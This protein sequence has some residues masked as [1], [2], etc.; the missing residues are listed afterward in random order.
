MIEERA[1]VGFD[2]GRGAVGEFSL[3]VFGV[4]LPEEDEAG[5]VGGPDAGGDGDFGFG[6]GVWGLGAIGDLFQGEAVGFGER[7]GECDVEGALVWAGFD[8]VDF[9][10]GGEGGFCFVGLDIL[11]EEN[12]DFFW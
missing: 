12:D 10:T 2:D 3:G 9:D 7:I 4:V 5:I 8:R 6:D 1:A 11:V